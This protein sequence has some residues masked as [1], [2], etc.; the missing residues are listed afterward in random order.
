[1]LDS[2]EEFDLP[3]LA[4]ELEAGVVTKDQGIVEWAEA[5]GLRHIGGRDF[6]TLLD[7]YLRA[8][9][10][11]C[12]PEWGLRSEDSRAVETETRARE[13]NSDG[14]RFRRPLRCFRYRPFVRVGF[15]NAPHAASGTSPSHRSVATDESRAG[16]AGC[17]RPAG[18]LQHRRVVNVRDDI[19]AVGRDRVDLGPRFEV[20][21]RHVAGPT[22]RGDDV[23][24][25]TLRGTRVEEFGRIRVDATGL[26]QEP[27]EPD[28]LGSE[29]CRPLAGQHREH[30]PGFE[31]GADTA[32][33]R[34]VPSRDGT[35]QVQAEVVGH[36]LELV[37]EFAGLAERPDLRRTA[38]ADPVERFFESTEATNCPC[39]SSESGYS[40]RM[41]RSSVGER[42]TPP[43]QTR[44]PPVSAT[45]RRIPSASNSTLQK[46]AI[47]SAVPAGEMMAREDVF[48]TVTPAATT[49][50]G[51]RA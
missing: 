10:D 6:P 8:S 19:R 17:A 1:M 51:G 9:V 11:R 12:Y 44:Q 47:V 49:M 48:G 36:L 24:E 15:P 20:R 41:M 3:V 37:G 16:M 25:R 50:G 2:R 30:L 18:H 40:A 31:D 21:E 13:W 26:E 5:F 23:A 42:S 35:R 43:P 22:L 33:D 7:E 32:A 4:R 29:V 45:M 27:R 46:T 39:G 34:R 14:R 38:W 28:A